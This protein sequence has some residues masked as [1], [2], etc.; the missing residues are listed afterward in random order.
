MKPSQLRLSEFDFEV[1]HGAGGI[2]KQWMR[3]PAFAKT[4][5]EKPC[6][7]MMYCTEVN[8]FEFWREKYW[9]KCKYLAYYTCHD[10]VDTVEPGT[11]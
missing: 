2:I 10:G 11:A 4:G 5:A 8:Q 6:S 9:D 7:K 1:V 3:Y